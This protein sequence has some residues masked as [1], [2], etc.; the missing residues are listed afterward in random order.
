MLEHLIY[1]ASEVCERDP[2]DEALRVRICGIVTAI[3][4]FKFLRGVLLRGMGWKSLQDSGT[5]QIEEMI[6]D[7]CR[8]D[9]LRA[10]HSPVR[11]QTCGGNEQEFLV[12]SKG[13]VR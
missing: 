1:A 12:T 7:I 8:G 9:F 4:S 10:Q 13:E 3:I 2:K 6:R 11:E 5:R